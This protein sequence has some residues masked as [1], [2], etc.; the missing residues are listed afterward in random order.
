MKKKKKL[1]IWSIVLLV[2]IGIC[3][4]MYYNR[5]KT[6]FINGI[7]TVAFGVSEDVKELGN[8]EIIEYSEKFKIPY[9][10]LYQLDTAYSGFLISL[11]KDTTLNAIVKNHYQ[12]LQAMY[13]NKDGR[14][15]SYYINCYAETS[16]LNLKW[17]ANNSFAV[18]PPLH[19]DG[20][21]PDT[22]FNFFQFHK[23]FNK[24]SEKEDTTEYRYDNYVVVFWNAFMGRQSK[25][26][27]NIVQQNRKLATGNVKYFFVDNDNFCYYFY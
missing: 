24:L 4:G 16:F 20:L 1:I 22:L 26:L 3:V 8:Q 21:E 18:F 11:R 19:Q 23:F 15:I 6:G 10:E 13:F 17:D 12:P 2:I 7:F 27:I 5:N 9:N 14:L 25:R